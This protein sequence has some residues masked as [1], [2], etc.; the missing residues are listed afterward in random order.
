[1]RPLPDG[2][3]AT[4][5]LDRGLGRHYVANMLRNEGHVALPMIDV[6]PNGEDQSIGDDTWIA[7]ASAEGWIA[8]T[9]DV[10]LIRD[11]EAA[12]AGS[13][14]RVFALNNANLAGEVMAE[15]YRQNLG[16]ILARAVQPGPYVYVVT[17]SGIERRWPR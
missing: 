3:K 7:R 10:S 4:F 2:G 14:L 5:F 6:Y 17:S 11:H 16:R 15:R 8:L 12:L 13:T 1:M 9:K